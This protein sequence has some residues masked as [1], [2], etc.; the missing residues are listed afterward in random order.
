MR[1]LLLLLLLSSLSFSHVLLKGEYARQMCLPSRPK[2]TDFKE[3]DRFVKSMAVLYRTNSY[4]LVSPTLDVFVLTEGKEEGKMILHGVFWKDTPVTKFAR[5]REMRK[6]H[7][8]TLNCTVHSEGE[9]LEVKDFA[10]WLAL[11]GMDA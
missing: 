11:V 5:F 1:I 3:N 2:I 7:V 4:A 6:W 9:M 8:D 10:V